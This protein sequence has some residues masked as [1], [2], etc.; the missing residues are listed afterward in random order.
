MII[1]I[2]IVESLRCALTAI[3]PE[4]KASLQTIS[5]ADTY[6]VLIMESLPFAKHGVIIYIFSFL[7]QRRKAWGFEPMLELGEELSSI[8]ETSV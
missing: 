1:L 5:K 4:Q 7:E 8:L 2:A 6:S 3:E